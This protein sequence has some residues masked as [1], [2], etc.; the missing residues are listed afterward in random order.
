M[1]YH[2]VLNRMCLINLSPLSLLDFDFNK[3]HVALNPSELQAGLYLRLC[4]M[5]PRELLPCGVFQWWSDLYLVNESA[6]VEWG[7]ML[8][9]G[10]ANGRDLE[11]LPALHTHL[12]ENSA[13]WLA[14]NGEIIATIVLMTLQLLYCLIFIH[15]AFGKIPH[16]FCINCWRMKSL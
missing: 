15:P 1:I 6:G 4:I 3:S 13:L 12:F 2:P 10:T 9:L 11:S 16:Y 14:T 5:L 7:Q 8:G